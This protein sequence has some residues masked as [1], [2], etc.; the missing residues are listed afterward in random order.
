VAKLG[1]VE[2]TRTPAGLG[3]SLSPIQS[4]NGAGLPQNA[5]RIGGAQATTGKVRAGSAVSS[6]PGSSDVWQTLEQL[7][8]R[9]R[10][11]ARSHA[12]GV[13][14]RVGDGCTD[15]ADTKLADSLGLHRR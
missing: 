9:D 10:I 8:E 14:D 2:L 6:R 12:G 11:V 13:V 4:G 7:I 5:E 15:P 3:G 1:V